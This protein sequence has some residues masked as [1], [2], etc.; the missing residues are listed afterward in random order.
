MTSAQLTAMTASRS[1]ALV[2]Q[3]DTMEA[4]EP[5]SITLNGTVY[6]AHVVALPVVPEQDEKTGLWLEKET[7]IIRLRK[8]LVATCPDQRS[9]VLYNALEYF[10]PERGQQKASDI[11]W[12]I[13]AKRIVKS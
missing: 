9:K 6:A 2:N 8:A 12:K 4:V 13:T 5:A 1:L 3:Q 11:A 10:I 7:L